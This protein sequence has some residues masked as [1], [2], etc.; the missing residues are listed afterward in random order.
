MGKARFMRSSLTVPKLV[1]IA[2][3]KL[4]RRRIDAPGPGR[5]QLRLR[6]GGE[7]FQER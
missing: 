4:L 1:E 7:S 3:T 5:K 6:I 2:R